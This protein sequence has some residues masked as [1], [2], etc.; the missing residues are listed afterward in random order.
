MRNRTILIATA[1]MAL[2]AGPTAEA[3]S[4]ACVEAQR[5][6]TIVHYEIGSVA[7]T[8]ADQ[9]RLRDFADVAR[10]KRDICVVGQ[11]DAQGDDASNRQLA[12][13]RAD[14]VA[15]LLVLYGVPREKI[16]VEVQERAVTLW[17][18]LSNDQPNDRR[19]LVTHN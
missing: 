7:T 16:S 9:E 12:Q 3:R 17:G 6:L 8:A 10:Y 2:V 13:A 5:G 14:S 4:D 11:A 15:G 19:V 1:L 18:A